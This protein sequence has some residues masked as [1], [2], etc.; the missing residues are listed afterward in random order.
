MK[1]LKGSYGL[2]VTVGILG[3][4]IAGSAFFYKG[5]SAKAKDLKVKVADWRE[6]LNAVRL[7]IPTKEHRQHL[8]EQK[9]QID[10]TYKQIVREALSW[11]YVPEKISGLDFQGNMLTTVRLIGAAAHQHS[12]LIQPKA[13]YLGFEEY[14][15][16]PPGL[17][18]DV[19]QLQREFSA[20]IDIVHLL[21]ASNVHSIERM[22][23]GDN[24]R[25]IEGQT[26][27]S[28]RFFTRETTTTKRRSSKYDFYT[29]VPFRV[30]F[31]C[32]YPSLAFFQK[33]L[34]TP[35]KVSMGQ[36][37]LPRNFF[38]VN[39][40]WF[41]VQDMREEGPEAFT[42]A[43]EKTR[44]ATYAM[45]GVAGTRKV[46]LPDDLPDAEG[47]LLREGQRAVWFF[48][49]WRTYSPEQKEIYRIERKLGQ[50]VSESD[51]ATLRAKRD[52]MM[53][54]LAYRKLPGRGPEYSILEVNMLIDFV[55]FNEK[56]VAELE[57]E[58]AKPRRSV[59]LT[60][61]TK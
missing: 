37:R 16:A 32:T 11:N 51:K 35:G 53:K 3:L 6:N 19:L 9:K 60:A 23:R 30:V 46:E 26:T 13:K 48:E 15:L 45:S 55:Q 41:K 61:T 54:E 8:E 28:T 22:A 21:I 47:L 1:R 17:D 4:A 31:S 24:A 44:T 58:P 5:E 25:M 57:A 39:D 33:S 42:S 12:I 36:E 40:M 59:S 50:Q 52:R 29:I 43:L 20:A 14:A 38:I 49:Q 2:Y 34:L 56:L 7:G 18:D 27:K 10:E